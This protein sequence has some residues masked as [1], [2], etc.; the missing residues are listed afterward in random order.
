M[1]KIYLTRHGQ[2][3]WNLEK[4]MQGHGESKLTEL[5]RKQARWLGEHLNNVHIDKIVSS[6]SGRTEETSRLIR[7][8]RPIAIEL[9]PQLREIHL[10]EWEGKL[11]HE[12]QSEFSEAYRNF[13]EDPL[14]YETS[15]GESLE[16][17]VARVSHEV[18]HI[19]ETY[20]GQTI[21]IVTHGVV[22]KALMIY[23]KKRG[24]EELWSGAFMH[25][26]TCLSLVEKTDGEWKIHMEGDT[27]HYQ[28][29]L[30]H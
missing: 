23:F 13:W 25:H 26:S 3:V 8:N 15:G 29:E 6:S 19:A 14:R 1:T 4:R 7:G 30:S 20:K 2:T 11:Q 17:L 28:E 24:I 27:T 12:L 16:E 10:G 18:E 5:G 21:L 22:L 9:N